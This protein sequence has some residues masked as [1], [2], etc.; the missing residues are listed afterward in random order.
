MIRGC[1]CGTAAQLYTRRFCW[2]PTQANKIFSFL[3][4]S[5]KQSSTTQHEINVSKFRL[6]SKVPFAHSAICSKHPEA[7][8]ALI[9]STYCPLLRYLQLF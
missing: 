9:G 5:N 3:R 6:S 7:T 2:I 4:C 1:H 8:I